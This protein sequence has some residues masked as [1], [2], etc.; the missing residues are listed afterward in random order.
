MQGA[1]EGRKMVPPVG[2]LGSRLRSI[3]DEYTAFFRAE[4]RS[5]V[6]TAFLIV[7]DSQRAED[8]AQDAF[9]QAYQHWR[10][11]LDTSDLSRGSDG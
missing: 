8:I 5:V 6:R 1:V 4:Y 10:K 11:S 9:V 3:D 7:Q 2:G